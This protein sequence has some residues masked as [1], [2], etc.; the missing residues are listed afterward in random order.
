MIP[1]AVDEASPK[2][3]Q[4]GFRPVTASNPEIYWLH[5]RGVRENGKATTS[6]SKWRLS[7]ATT[8]LLLQRPATTRGRWQDV[9]PPKAFRYNMAAVRAGLCFANPAN[10]LRSFVPNI[11]P[12]LAC[13]K[14]IT[15]VTFRFLAARSRLSS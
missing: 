4:P 6:S 14:A 2:F 5:G 1:S 7:I 12:G 10:L 3:W 15:T 11:W 8:S 9:R 13:N